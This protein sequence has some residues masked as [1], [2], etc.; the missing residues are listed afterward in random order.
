MWTVVLSSQSPVPR[1]LQA[2]GTPLPSPICHRSCEDSLAPG[3]VHA[4]VAL[5]PSLLV[6]LRIG[7]VMIGPINA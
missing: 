2:R 7:R 4:R 6:S 3:L 5:S 1:L